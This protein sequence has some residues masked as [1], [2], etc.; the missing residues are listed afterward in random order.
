MDNQIIINN[1]SIQMIR[2]EYQAPEMTVFVLCGI[3]ETGKHAGTK[4][5]TSRIIKT[6][7]GNIV[8][9]KSGS[10]Y[11]L[12]AP[13]NNYLSFLKQNNFKI[14]LQNVFKK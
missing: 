4:I 1:W 12:G 9:T 3:P 5:C 10:I 8:H 14:N 11:K 6:E 2:G 13:S 7:D